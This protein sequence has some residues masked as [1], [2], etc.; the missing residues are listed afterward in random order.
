MRRIFVIAGILL[1]VFSFLPALPHS[2]KRE[3]RAVWLSTVSNIDWPKSR[4]DSDTKKQNDLRNYLIKLKESGCNA[5]LF[6]VRCSCDAMYKSQIEPWSYWFSGKQGRAP[7]LDWDPLTF[8]VEEAHKLGM[9]LHAWVNPYRAVVNPTST[10]L[11]NSDYLSEGHVT[12][13]HPEWILKFS[14]V[15][16]LDPGLPE[17]RSYIR[18]VLMDIVVRYDIDGLHMDDYFYPYSGITTQDTATFSLDPRGF[19][20]IHD[21]R[22]DNINLLVQSVMDSI[23]HSKSWV[24]W[25]ISPFGIYRPGVP[26]GIT[27]MDAYNVLY[28]DPL[29]WL[30][31]RSV[32]YLTPQCYWPFGGGQ[33]YGKL[34]PWWAEQCLANERHFYPGQAM[35]R[36]GDDNFPRGEISRQIRLNRKTPNCD[37]SVFFTANDF[38]DNHKNTID[39]LKLDLYRYPALWPVMTWK[40]SSAPATPQNLQFLVDGTGTKTLSWD[41]PPYSDPSDS[42]YAY[43]VYR[44]PYLPEN[45]E[46]MAHVKRIDFSRQKNFSDSDP[47]MYYYR[48]TA[49]D[50]N[51]VE[52][53]AG[54]IDYPFVRQQYPLYAEFPVSK[55]AYFSW[56]AFP[57]AGQYTLQISE[58]GNFDSP[59]HQQL[60][61]DTT[62]DQ[63]LEYE[64]Q[65]AWRVK[66]DN[67]EHWSPVWIFNTEYAPPVDVLYPLAF[68]EGIPQEFSFRWRPYEDAQS[69]DLQ[70]ASDPAMQNLLFDYRNISDTLQLLSGLE[71]ANDYY[72]HIRPNLYEQWNEVQ[73]FRTRERHIDV[74]W[75]HSVFADNYSHNGNNLAV[76]R[77]NGSPVLIVLSGEG[78]HCAAT[79]LHAGNG[80]L[81]DM[82]LN[83]EG[84]GGGTHALRDICISADGV[85]YAANLAEADESFKVYRWEN[86]GQAPA[87]VYRADDIAYRLGDHISLSESDDGALTLY[88]PAANSDKLLI[89]EWNTVSAAF[90]GRQLTL[91]RSNYA[92]PS[93]AEV[94]G[95]SDI[96]STSAGEYLIRY[97]NDGNLASWTYGNKEV[98]MNLSSLA[99]FSWQDK[100]FVAAYSSDK[101]S[102]YLYDC[103]NSLRSILTAGRTY[104]L[105]NEENLANTGDVEVL[106]NGDGTFNIYVLGH[107]NGLAAYCFDVPELLSSA[108]DPVLAAS[109]E[110]GDNYPN[111]FNPVTS[112]PYRLADAGNVDI[113]VYD[114]NGRHIRTLY[115]GYQS[116][117]EYSIRFDARN[118]S[119]GV[120]ICR[121]KAGDRILTRKMTLLK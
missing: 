97:K 79:I 121:L 47:G 19:E 39:S 66:A 111:P 11:N 120:Y 85:I 80:M 95:S 3:F 45:N 84:V 63:L 90:E 115:Q 20:N 5:V 10:N 18:D 118:L 109:Y 67:S 77:I 42:A 1:L 50:R 32:D 12:R 75:D 119:S 24:K 60:L 93:V 94:P 86:P 62:A 65:Y 103:G 83:L 54:L 102:A 100:N 88:A 81:L 69:Y 99:S 53:P 57:G 43:I 35:Y 108:E 48:V 70:V 87:L 106:D 6:Q 38:Y 110:L 37:G 33:D 76:G 23:N 55:Q 107:N 2:P 82:T 30:E 105:G 98:P 28:C 34:I 40:D 116:A 46:D 56:H 29:A 36:A 113:A 16:I 73:S 89:L 58:D 112:I 59:L 14:D 25:G 22:R 9:E 72:W 117:G 7:E 61:A 92:M 96:Y 64:R 17:V 21:W 78:V 4:Y 41:A 49:L 13:T 74:L 101:E 8:A 91:K 26:P 68:L 31:D 104:R 71:T 15:Y 44:A 51:K 114:L 52:S 27:G